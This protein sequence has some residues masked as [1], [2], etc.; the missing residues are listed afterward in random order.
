MKKILRITLIVILALSSL[1][2]NAV[3]LTGN[4]VKAAIAKQVIEQYNQYTDAQLSVEVAGIPFKD[5]YLP[6]GKVSFKI[7]SSANKFMARDLEKVFVFVDN[8]LVRTFT[9]PVIV[10]A[11]Q[12]VLVSSGTIE[13]EKE[14]NL[15]VARIEK[16]EVSNNFGY[17]LKPEDLSKGFLTKKYFTEGEI[18]DKRFVKQRPDVLR[19]SNVTVFFNSNN[20]TISLEGTALAD[21]TIG[22]NICVINKNYNK[23]YKGTV[24]GENRILVKI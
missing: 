14:I 8:N 23:I 15:S 13:R 3:I 1:K 11:Y 21:G 9:A 5:L 2:A 16:K 22:D 18:I 19:N 4:E 7:K 6:N 10:K 20:L 12:D 17:Y 24:V